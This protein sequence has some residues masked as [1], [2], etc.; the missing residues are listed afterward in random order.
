[1]RVCVLW[2]C[3]CVGE[4]VG[5]QACGCVVVRVSVRV[6]VWLC[7]WVCGCAVRNVT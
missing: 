5:V 2:V 6:C 1:V 7:G 3:G 4:R